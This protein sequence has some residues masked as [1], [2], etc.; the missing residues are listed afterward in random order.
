MTVIGADV[1]RF[2][3][4]SVAIAVSVYV[5]AATPFQVNAYGGDSAVPMSVSPT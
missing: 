3:A 1:P 2:T 5:P 4:L